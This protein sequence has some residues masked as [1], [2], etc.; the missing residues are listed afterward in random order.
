VRVAS[1]S[2]YQRNAGVAWAWLCFYLLVTA[3]AILLPLKSKRV[4]VA[5]T[6]ASSVLKLVASDT[7]RRSGSEPTRGR[8]AARLAVI[9]GFSAKYS[10]RCA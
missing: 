7:C 8:D 5:A 2:V 9:G 10:S 6:R 3:G 4:D 1:E